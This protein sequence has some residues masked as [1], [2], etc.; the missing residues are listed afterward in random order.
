ME[1]VEKPSEVELIRKK[2]EKHPPVI[3]NWSNCK[4]DRLT[5]AQKRNIVYAKITENTKKVVYP[6]GYRVLRHK[7]QRCKNV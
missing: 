2:N 4:P 1:Q 5:T 3:Y 6:P 7:K